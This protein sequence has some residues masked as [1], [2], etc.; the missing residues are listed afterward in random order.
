MINFNKLKNK[1]FIAIILI[2]F[3][4][5]VFCVRINT[6]HGVNLDEARYIPAGV[7]HWQTCEFTLANDSPPLARMVTALPLLLFE[8]NLESYHL[9]DPG[10]GGK[11]DLR[12]RELAYGG[13]FASGERNRLWYNLFCLARMMGF[14]WWLLGAWVVF[15]WSGELYGGA[16]G[17]LATA[18]WCFVPNILAY[19]QLATPE[20]PASVVC[21]S[22]TYVFRGY[23]IAP[24]W[25]KALAAG[26]LLGVAQLVAFASLTLFV[27]W[28]L[29]ALLQRFAPGIGSSLVVK[30]L[31]R[32]LQ[33]A[34]AIALSVW[35]VN[36]GYGL[37]DSG[38]HLESIDFAS[39]AL[40]RD[41][42]Q[43]DDPL[44]NR[45]GGNRFRNSWLGR[46]I[47]PLPMDYVKGLDRVLHER[48]TSHDRPGEGERVVKVT[49]RSLVA[50]GD[51]I[52]FGICG[53]MLWSLISTMRRPPRDVSW[54][55]VLTP[56]VPVA[57]I[58]PLTTSALGPLSPSVGIILAIPFGIISASRLAWFLQPGPGM[59]GWIAAALSLWAVGDSL[60]A[61][62]AY[63]F[64]PE[65]VAHF[66][67]D[68][69]H[70]RR[71]LGLPEF[72]PR[73]NTDDR[74]RERGLLYRTF[75]DSRGV[76]IRYSLFV[77]RDYRGDRHWPLILFLHGYGDRGTSGRQFTAVGLP[78]TLEYRNINFLVLCPQGRSGY[79]D[80]SGDD[81]RRAMEMLAAV[82]KEYRVDPK[83]ISLTGLS[84]GGEGVWSLAAGYPDR[85]AAIVPVA[86]P[87]IG[88]G[89]A[90][91]IQHIPCWCFHN[92]YD[93]GSP[94]NRI[95]ETIEVLRRAGGKPRYTEFLD[96]NHSAWDWA[97]D[98]T[99]LY[100]WLSQQR[101]P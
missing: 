62:R 20:L 23:L 58:L 51:R 63:E 13:R 52:P 98:L 37:S 70:L 9:D 31:S 76:A 72:E 3:A 55:D 41:S 36:I 8:V 89:Q 22:A 73:R 85:W 25:K 12:A 10:V 2:N 1:I 94:A 26:L 93:G 91:R 67:R 21:L 32:M 86:S 45:A 27:I 81:G 71:K 16:A 87:P 96:I 11:S 97:Y 18:L 43:P 54:A 77:P 35:V 24:S 78:L 4:L 90:L 101:L 59:S 83:R 56:W 17:L 42:R 19:E 15:R 99:E 66:R 74:D 7:Y 80:A 53:M 49:D 28:P 61:I 44:A 6:L 69:E 48:E 75:V 50:A 38:S 46:V 82:Q 84:S 92:R 29:L 57:T 88:R 60:V 47:I 40:T 34:A 5:L 68:L 64:T 14:P 100:D 30:P 33:V 39:R 65:N 79:W 95:R